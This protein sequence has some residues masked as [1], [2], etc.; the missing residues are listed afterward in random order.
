METL[1]S[2]L[3]F[4]AVTAV[5]TFFALKKQKS[6]WTGVLVD[7][8]HTEDDESGRDFYKLIF[9]TDGGK[10]IKWDVDQNMYNTSEIGKRFKKEKGDLFPQ[11][12]D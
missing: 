7:K 1:Y 9:K 10:K 3:A 2:I 8:T 12:T 4:L 6:S 11:Q 5:L